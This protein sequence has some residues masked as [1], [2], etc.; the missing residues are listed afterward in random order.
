MRCFLCG[1]PL[2]LVHHGLCSQCIRHLPPLPPCC[3]RCGLPTADLNKLCYQCR[4]TPPPWDSLVAVSDYLVPLK[5]LIQRLK[6]YRQTQ[7]AYGLARL[8]WLTWYFNEQKVL[9]GRPDRVT[10]V[11]L[12]RS[13]YWR[14]GFNQSALLAKPLARWLGGEFSPFL[15]TQVQKQTPQKTLLASARKTNLQN[16]FTCNVDLAGEKIILLDDIVTTGSTIFA[17]SEQLRQQGAQA[18][19]VI[20]LCRT[21][22][23]YK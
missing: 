20:C 23:N 16:T 12:H 1:L 5:K 7:L 11:P 18:I 4:Q 2:V 3:R 14:R 22:K 8:L 10:C 9:F 17:V 15:L 19:Q 13:K 21:L 6:F